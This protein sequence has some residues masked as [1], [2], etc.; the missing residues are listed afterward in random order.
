M[1]IFLRA[2]PTKNQ[3]AQHQSTHRSLLL[4]GDATPEEVRAAADAAALVRLFQQLGRHE[5]ALCGQRRK[6]VLAK[7]FHL[8]QRAR[9][10]RNQLHLQL[11]VGNLLLVQRKRLGSE[12]G[13]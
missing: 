9:E 10:L 5:G 8:L 3:G 6:V 13:M 7:D 2:R 12:S 4:N 1:S 11:R